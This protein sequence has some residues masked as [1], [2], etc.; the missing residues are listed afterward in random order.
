MWSASRAVGWTDGSVR[1]PRWKSEV[2]AEDDGE[3]NLVAGRR[4]VIGVYRCISVKEK[5]LSYGYASLR[6]LAAGFWPDTPRFCGLCVSFEN[7]D[8]R[9][10][11]TK[12]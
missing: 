5:I 6:S 1:R 4:Y 10:S 7:P 11:T 3:M 2:D 8:S 12:V 9:L